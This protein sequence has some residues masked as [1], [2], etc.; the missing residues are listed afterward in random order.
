MDMFPRGPGVSSD[1][2]SMVDFFFLAALSL[3]LKMERDLSDSA[4][5]VDADAVAGSESASGVC[6]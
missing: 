2:S 5:E 3:R 4:G 1:S 6:S